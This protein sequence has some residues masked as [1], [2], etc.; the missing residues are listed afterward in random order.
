MELP[1]F[2]LEPASAEALPEGEA[3]VPPSPAPDRAFDALTWLT[4]RL[5]RV[6]AV[7]RT[8]ASPSKTPSTTPGSSGS[9]GSWRT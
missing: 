3:P 1:A 9:G 7:R 4:L 6:G 8:R 5:G 2:I